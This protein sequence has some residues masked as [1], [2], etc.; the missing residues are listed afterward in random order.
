MIIRNRYTGTV[1][2]DLEGANLRYA[3]LK[4]AN[5]ENVHLI[6]KEGKN[7]AFNTWGIQ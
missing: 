7:E 1:I 6:F 3:N 5:L 2:I 4:D